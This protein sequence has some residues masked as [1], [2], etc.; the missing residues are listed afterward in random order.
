MP[1]SLALALLWKKPMNQPQSSAPQTTPPQNPSFRPAG[2]E[3]EKAAAVIG[4]AV[5]GGLVAGVL[6]GSRPLSSPSRAR[7]GAP[8]S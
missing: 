7:A 3:K 4:L 6:A 2:Y 5:L 1:P 8:V